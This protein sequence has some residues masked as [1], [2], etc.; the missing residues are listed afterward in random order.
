MQLGGVTGYDLPT[1]ADP[2]LFRF[3]LKRERIGLV[4]VAINGSCQKLTDGP[5]S[6][7]R[8]KPINSFRK[9]LRIG[10]GLGVNLHFSSKER[11]PTSSP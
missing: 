11:L 2:S 8:S 9:A 6:L 10:N 4:W 5:A 3:N 7:L 1:T